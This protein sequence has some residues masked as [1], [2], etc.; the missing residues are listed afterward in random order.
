MKIP[1]AISAALVGR[2]NSRYP[3]NGYVT[4]GTTPVK[5]WIYRDFNSS[6]GSQNLSEAIQHS[7]NPY[8]NTLANVIG[9]EALVEG[10]TMMNIGRR[11]GIE[12]PFESPGLLPGSR[13][14]RSALPNEAMNPHTIAMLSIGQ[15]NTMAT[16][17]QACAITAC[18]AN[19]G[20]YY[21]PRI[22]KQVVSEYG[23]VLVPDVP[24]LHV[25][26][27]KSGV[28][29]SDL[30]LIRNGMRMS[31]NERGGTSGKAKLAKVVVAS[32]SG[33]AQCTDDGKPSNNS[34]LMSFAPYE[35]PKYAVCILVQNGGSG[36]GVCGPMVN[37]V[38]RG[39]FA[40]DNGVRLPLRNIQKVPGNT[41]RIAKTIE[42]SP[43]LIAAVEAGE[44]PPLGPGALLATHDPSQE[45]AT[46][47]EGETG[48]EAGEHVAVE[49]PPIEEVRPVTPSPTITPE[50]DDEGTVIPRAVP[51]PER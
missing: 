31:T 44:M 42:I 3:C 30:E 29:P 18:V 4:Y 6:H 10:F 38:L 15:G 28:K 11:T 24:K 25:D 16:P 2:G 8:F 9:R 45:P 13:A 23:K 50:V 35:N 5:C 48:D 14:W 20:K 36:G 34:W 41:D 37:L 40:R 51:V 32:K 19:G 47:E 17:L 12:L 39:L 49:T 7:C 22:I 43:D 21:T 26:L 27:I 46:M 1:V 33:T